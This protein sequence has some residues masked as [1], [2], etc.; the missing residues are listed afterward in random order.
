VDPITRT[1]LWPGPPV[2]AF[3]GKP[4]RP[5]PS[6]RPNYARDRYQKPRNISWGRHFRERYESEFCPALADAT[7]IMVGTVFNAIERI[8]RPEK[9][10]DLTGGKAQLFSEPIYGT[11]AGRT[12]D[13]DVFSPFGFSL[14]MGGGR[15]A[16]VGDAQDPEAKRAKGNEAYDKAGRSPPRNSS[17]CWPRPKPSSEKRR[18]P[19]G[20]TFWEGLWWSGLRL[21]ESLQLTWDRQDRLCVDMSAKH[22]ML[23]IPPNSKRANK[24]RL[25]PMAPEFCEVPA[26]HPRQPA[27]G[28]RFPAA[29]SETSSRAHRR[30]GVEDRRQNRPTG[31]GEGAYKPQNG[32][33]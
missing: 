29:R 17:G 12:H 25:L 15:G 11:A 7:G 4:K 22:P 5:P 19:H 23:W 30:L 13:S 6:G 3:G 18:R 28:T 21:G 24:D 33:R 10:H 27:T 2:Q 1:S 9:L 31:P 16:A 32:E 14:E 26:K 8:L 20:V